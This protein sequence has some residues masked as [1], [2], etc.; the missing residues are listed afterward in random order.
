[1]LRYDYKV[2]WHDRDIDGFVSSTT[3]TPPVVVV[4]EGTNP[5]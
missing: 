3:T 1:M 2:N 5:F 4:V